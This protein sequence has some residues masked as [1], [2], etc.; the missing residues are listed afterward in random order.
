MI[1]NGL[2]DLNNFLFAAMEELDNPELK[3]DELKD[4]LAKSKV[5]VDVASKIIDNANTMLEATK[6][7]AEI[8]GRSNVSV[9]KTL[10][11]DGNN[12]NN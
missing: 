5:K 10:L 9:P 4:V 3:G 1:K 6:V 11:G 12:G 8:L 7:Q 2:M